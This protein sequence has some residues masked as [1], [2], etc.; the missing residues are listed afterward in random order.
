MFPDEERMFAALERLFPVKDFLMPLRDAA[1]AP[2]CEGLCSYK[3]CPLCGFYHNLLRNA[4][5]AAD[6]PLRFAIPVSCDSP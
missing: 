4:K 2:A 6:C 3:V 1:F 5:V